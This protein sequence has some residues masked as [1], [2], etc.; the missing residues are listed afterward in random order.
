MSTGIFVQTRA[1]QFLRGQFNKDIGL[2][3][4]SHD[5][6]TPTFQQTFWTMNDNGLAVRAFE[7]LGDTNTANM[8][9]QQLQSLPLPFG[10]NSFFNN[11]WADCFIHQEII[12]PSPFRGT[13]CYRF[14]N[15]SGELSPSMDC[16]G[17]LEGI[18]HEEANGGLMRDEENYF[19]L[20]ASKALNCHKAGDPT[21]RDRLVAHIEQFWDNDNTGFRD[22][23]D[24]P[25]A[26]L[27]N[28]MKLA[29]YIILGARC[30]WPPT[31]STTLPTQ[32]KRLMNSL[33][34]ANGGF[35]TQ[36]FI[37]NGAIYWPRTDT[38]GNIETTSV[39]VLANINPNTY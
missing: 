19:L 22:M 34:L 29:V 6:S 3:Y 27:K 2:C 32:A 15:E 20:S 12:T 7:R 24:T 31:F 39:C 28:T 9:A 14:L 35:A 21:N 4:E 8:I 5:P 11:G 33:Q 16:K 38:H 23:I 26:S 25:P 36:Y 10:H 37:H 13:Q 1:L 30:G 17:G 18:M